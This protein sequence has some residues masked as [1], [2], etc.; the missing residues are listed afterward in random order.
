MGRRFGGSQGSDAR[1]Q[2]RGIIILEQRP[3]IDAEVPEQAK[4]QLSVAG[5]PQPVAVGAKVFRI[6]RDDA[7]APPGI[8]MG[9]FYRRSS[10][11]RSFHLP[12]AR[13]LQPCYDALTRDVALRMAKD[14]PLRTDEGHYILDLSLTRIG[15]PR[16]LAL[17]L[18][19]VP[20]VVENGLFID[21]CDVVIIGHGDGRVDLRDITAGI[22]TEEKV[23]LLEE[24]NLFADLG[25]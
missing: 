5:Q 21:I 18:N 7:D 11:R 14:Q 13:R 4:V 2:R 19:Q 15:N 12:P 24:T 3:E 20:G 16:Q 8:G 25:D 9:I 6:G 10:S 17:V 22:R 23:D 1:L